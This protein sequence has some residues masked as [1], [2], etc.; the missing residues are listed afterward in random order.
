MLLVFVSF[1]FALVAQIGNFVGESNPFNVTFDDYGQSKFEDLNVPL[2][3]IIKNITF[4]ARFIPDSYSY[5][6]FIADTDLIA[7]W[8]G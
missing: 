4:S 1:V 6:D 5:L 3:G 8:A 2:F 7:Y